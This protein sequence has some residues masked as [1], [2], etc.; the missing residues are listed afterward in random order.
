MARIFLADCDIL[1]PQRLLVLIKWLAS[2]RL[3]LA[4]AVTGER[5]GRGY[6]IGVRFVQLLV[7]VLEGL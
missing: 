2:P 4:C 3:W 1:P 6:D 5:A 7:D